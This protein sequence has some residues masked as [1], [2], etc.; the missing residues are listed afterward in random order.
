MKAR[1]LTIVWG[2]QHLDWFERAC[3][4]SLGQRDNFAALAEHVR[5]WD[6]VTQSSDAAAV[7]E[8]ASRLQLPVELHTDQSLGGSPG[9]TLQREIMA[10]MMRC[11]DD[12]SALFMAPPDSIFGD[13]T[14]QSV[15]AIGQPKAVCVAV[16]HVRVT[17][18]ILKEPAP[19]RTNAA[20]VAASWR[21]LHRTWIEAEATREQTNTWAGGVSWRKVGADLYAVTH[22]L[23]TVYLAQFDQ[24]DLQWWT[25]WQAQRGLNGAWDHFWPSKLVAESRQRVVGS[26]DAAFIAEVTPEFGNIPPCSASDPEEPDKCWGQ[27]AH[28]VINR[29]VMAFFRA[30]LPPAMHLSTGA[31]VL[32]A[33]E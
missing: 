10:Q 32:E 14:V 17:P 13:G 21:H 18:Q 26:S 9:M 22:R 31:P 27:G 3:V 24:T 1:M 20:L 16:P 4:A 11:L 23:P 30:E 19:G 7:Q 15:F 6:I 28:F 8:I 25:T 33:A 12:Q 2:P 5:T 29:N